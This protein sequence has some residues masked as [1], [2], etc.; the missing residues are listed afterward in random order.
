MPDLIQILQREDWD[1]IL[2]SKFSY[3][4]AELY[5]NCAGMQFGPFR[6]LEPPMPNRHNILKDPPVLPVAKV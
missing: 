1:T 2:N 3:G 4:P 6:T 5:T